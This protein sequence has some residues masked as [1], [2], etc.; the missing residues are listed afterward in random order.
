MN[1]SKRKWWKDPEMI[2]ALSAVLLGVV[3]L[4]IGAYQAKVSSDQRAASVWPYLSVSRFSLEGQEYGFTLTNKGVG[5][6]LIK[7]MEVTVNGKN[8]PGWSS[9]FRA[10]LNEKIDIPS[11]YSSTNKAVVAV[12]EKIKMVDLKNKEIIKKVQSTEDNIEI[13]ICYCSIFKDC[14]LTG[15]GIETVDVKS[16]NGVL[17]DSFQH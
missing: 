17:S 3:A 9:A 14:W 13:K 6:A 1:E 8:V 12:Q 2:T 4:V 15:R 16:C 5:P 11:I 10:M 7:S